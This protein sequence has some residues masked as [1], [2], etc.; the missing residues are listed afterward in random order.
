MKLWDTAQDTVQNTLGHQLCN[1]EAAEGLH[2]LI[3]ANKLSLT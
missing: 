3:K 1:L 2:L